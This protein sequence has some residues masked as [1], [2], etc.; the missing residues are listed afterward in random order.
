MSKDC[1]NERRRTDL[2][3]SDGDSV[4]RFTSDA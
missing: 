4:F 3:A 1:V 2:L